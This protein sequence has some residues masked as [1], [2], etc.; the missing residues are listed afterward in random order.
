MPIVVATYNVHRCVG[1]DGRFDPER[2]LAVLRELDADA[3]ALQELQWR[4][5]DAMHLLQELALKLGYAALAG[6]TLLRADGHYGNAVLTRLPLLD[7]AT[8]DLSVPGREPRG[9]LL[10]LLETPAGPLRLIATHLGLRPYERRLQMR[11]LLALPRERAAATVLLGDLNEWFLWGRPL[12]WLH[13]RFGHTP[14]PPSF[15]ARR[16]LLALD[17]IWVE[18]RSILRGL[19]AHASPLARVASDHLPLRAVLEP[20]AVQACPQ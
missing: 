6:P 10:A 5:D 3:V 15:P 16:P 12:R 2:T 7:T 13:A 20:H 19:H 18:P 17:R 1:R 14:A 4:P 8:V 9:A 11:R